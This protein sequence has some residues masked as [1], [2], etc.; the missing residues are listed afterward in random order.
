MP[1][2]YNCPQAL[3]AI[4]LFQQVP[5]I[6][7]LLLAAATCAFGLFLASATDPAS[8]AEEPPAALLATRHAASGRPLLRIGYIEQSFSPSEREGFEATFA[9]LRKRLPQYDVSIDP[10]LVKDLERA[11][12]E[13]KV[14]FFL[15][16]SGFYRRVYSRGLRDIATMTTRVAPNPN[17][18]IATVFL[19]PNES[20]IKTVAD[21]RG[22]K[23]A[24]NWLNGWSGVFIPLK[25][26]QDEGY[27]PDNF[28]GGLVAAGSPMRKL[29]LAVLRGEADV[30]MS[31][32]CTLEEL[33]LTEPGLAG[34]FRPIGLKPDN[35][36]DFK[37]LR[38]TEVYPNWTFVSTSL[39]PWQ[40]SR[41]VAAALLT[42]PK[43]QNGTGWAVVSD[44]TQVDNLYKSLRR[45]P[46]EYLRIRSV[47]DFI[48]RYWG[49]ICLGFMGILALIFHS[50]YVRYL[51]SV[52]TR[53][54][55]EAVQ[56]ER[57]AEAAQKLALEQI[58]SLERISTIGAVSSMITHELNGP[59]SVISNSCN[60][61]QRQF[62]RSPVPPQIEK[63]IELIARQCEKASGIV[64][65]VRN[66]VRHRDA[67]LEPIDLAAE[68]TRIF[69]A[70]LLKTPVG[71]LHL[72][73]QAQGISVFWNRLELELCL[74]NVTKNAIE[75][76]E[77]YKG[78]RIRIVLTTQ[79]A[80]SKAII[81]VLDNAPTGEDELEKHSRPLNTSK[82]TGTGL[83]LLIVR[84]LC[85]KASGNFTIG[86]LDGL[87]EA[88]ITLPIFNKES[89]HG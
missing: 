33:R 42:M 89:A 80:G 58:Q 56:K 77:G 67:Q 24:V 20:P 43:T 10:Y 73:I 46:Y 72:D 68:L 60:A 35:L 45:G 2:S 1:L 28:F 85:E 12:R 6:L 69:N 25:E 49:F 82:A 59:I 87:T 31:R 50:W 19:V 55:R 57:E 17:Q 4:F 54:L 27:D 88:R 52:R 81:S 16:A 83:G 26:L 18:A 48:K 23:A 14:E 40:M 75:A 3:R 9:Y 63:A 30:A 34:R 7:S 74:R 41:D 84:T 38:S 51:V 78:A 36:S 29:L 32:S 37:C 71:M 15:G 39:A 86:R 64:N 65:H 66:Y 13:N 53:E 76:C 22:K 70:W 8:S 21:L 11:I 44:F 47:S 62:E 79:D 61:L 5:R